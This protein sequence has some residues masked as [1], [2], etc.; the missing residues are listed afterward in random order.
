L[1]GEKAHIHPILSAYVFFAQATRKPSGPTYL[2]SEE[3]NQIYN[4]IAQIISEKTDQMLLL[5]PTWNNLSANV[6]RIFNR[7]HISND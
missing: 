3:D 5:P 1:K 7:R 4:S 6:R 2:F